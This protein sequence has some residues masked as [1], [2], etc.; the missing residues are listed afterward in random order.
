MRAGADS[1]QA[2]R[3]VPAGGP[4]FAVP[5]RESGSPCGSISGCPMAAD[6]RSASAGVNRCSARSACSVH[7]ADRHPQLVGEIELP[8]P[9][10]ADDVQGDAFALAGQPEPIA[11]GADQAFPLRRS[12]SAS[13]V[14]SLVPRAPCSE[15]RVPD[16]PAA[17]WPSRCLSA[18][19]ACSRLRADV[20]MA[21]AARA[22]RRAA[23]TPQPMRPLGR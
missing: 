9:V 13:S 8:E 17:A 2:L 23:R 5:A 15:D 20:V 16:W 10:G 12:G 14:R 1:G 19:S 3:G 18:F 21:P 7:L 4:Q 22:A 11:F 6:R